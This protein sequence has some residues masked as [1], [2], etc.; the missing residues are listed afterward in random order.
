M[1]IKTI[2]RVSANYQQ[3][4]SFLIL[5]DYNRIITEKKARHSY[6]GEPYF[7]LHAVSF[8]YNKQITNSTKSKQIATAE[9]CFRKQESPAS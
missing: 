4:K 7:V 9:I 3:I 2:W 6:C 1:P 8:S 5:R